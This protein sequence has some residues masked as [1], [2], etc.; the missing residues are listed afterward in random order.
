MK[1]LLAS[2][3]TA[4]A[5]LWLNACAPASALDTPTT[6]A[7]TRPAPSGGERGAATSTASTSTA[8]ECSPLPTDPVRLGACY[9]RLQRELEEAVRQNRDMGRQLDGN[10]QP[11]PPN[12]TTSRGITRPGTTAAAPSGDV[13]TA[14]AQS[15]L[16]QTGGATPTGGMPGV[17]GGV[18]RVLGGGAIPIRPNLAMGNLANVNGPPPVQAMGGEDSS[19]F[20]IGRM[21][22]DVDGQ[23]NGRA[24]EFFVNGRRICTSL[25]GVDFAE[26]LTTQGHQ[27]CV[28]P[29]GP[30]GSAV[31]LQFNGTEYRPVTVRAR[32]YRIPS[33]DGQAR[34]MG[35][36]VFTVRPND[37]FLLNDQAFH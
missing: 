36:A 18:P 13:L 26:V 10:V 1:K 30:V 25:N 15:A 4:V 23:R 34:F 37:S 35:E 5:A 16:G 31:E 19:I 9:E 21:F 22:M 29:G 27:I 17:N 7:T 24:T 33:T 20:V 28:L 12:P 3:F 6:P 11:A 2:C 32:S 8:S 14:L